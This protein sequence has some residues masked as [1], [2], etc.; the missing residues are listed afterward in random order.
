[1][2]IDNVKVQIA[3]SVSHHPVGLRR[4]VSKALAT[5]QVIIS[6]TTA[7][8]VMPLSRMPKIATTPYT[9]NSSNHTAAI[10]V[11]MPSVTMF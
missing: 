1:M 11:E 8:A 3:E 5:S 9:T 4:N 7:T 2:I 6:A 10:N